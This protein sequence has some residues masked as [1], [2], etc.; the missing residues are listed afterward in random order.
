MFRSSQTRLFL[1]K[2]YEKKGSSKEVF[3]YLLFIYRY[4]LQKWTIIYK[5][6]I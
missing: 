2:N 6:N 1:F 4:W 5:T 3:I